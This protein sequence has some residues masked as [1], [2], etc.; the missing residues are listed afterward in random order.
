MGERCR[1]RGC[2]TYCSTSGIF[3]LDPDKPFRIFLIRISP[4]LTCKLKKAIYIRYCTVQGLQQDWNL[5]PSS[6]IQISQLLTKILNFLN[7]PVLNCSLLLNPIIQ[8]F[9]SRSGSQH[10]MSGN[11]TLQLAVTTWAAGTLLRSV[12]TSIL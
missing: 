1:R 9:G 3:I 12:S 2:I 4:C 5:N 6:Q 7:K 8:K 11:G 10:C